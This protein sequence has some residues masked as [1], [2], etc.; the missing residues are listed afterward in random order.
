MPRI[1][2]CIFSPSSSYTSWPSTST[3]SPLI[4][5]SNP[6]NRFSL[7]TFYSLPEIVRP[8]PIV[9][10]LWSQICG[11]FIIEQAPKFPHKE[12]KLA[13]VGLTNLLTHSSTMMQEP[14][15][16]TWFVHVF[17]LASLLRTGSP[18]RS[19]HMTGLLY[20][21]PLKSFSM[22]AS[23]SRTRHKPPLTPP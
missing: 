1:S 12:R 3:E 7:S 6:L 2:S 18:I 23:I 8:S 22:S 15:I 10:R 21:V 17:V 14:Y 13:V 9:L 5:S 16:R 20:T 4:S 19:S 11:K